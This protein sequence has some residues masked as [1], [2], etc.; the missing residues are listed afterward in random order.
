MWRWFGRGVGEGDAKTYL[1]QI[2]NEPHQ[3]VALKVRYTLAILLPVKYL[4]ELIAKPGC[5]FVE[6]TELL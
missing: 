6:A 1:I 2:V 3:I 5:G 4:A